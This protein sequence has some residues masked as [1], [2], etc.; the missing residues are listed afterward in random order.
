M[1]FQHFISTFYFISFFK[2]RYIDDVY[3]GDY[4][5]LVDLEANGELDKVLRYKDYENGVK[6][7]RKGEAAR[8]TSSPTPTSQSTSSKPNLTTSQSNKP[9]GGGLTTSQ[10]AKPAGAKFCAGN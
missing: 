3:I 7:Y 2:K 4:K 9:S 6:G 8:G 5:K 1:L 10:S